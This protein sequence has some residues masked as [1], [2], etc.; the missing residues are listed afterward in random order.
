[1]AINKIRA[2]FDRAGDTEDADADA[3]ADDKKKEKQLVLCGVVGRGAAATTMWYDAGMVMRVLRA[4]GFY[5]PV[6]AEE[7][8]ASTTAAQFTPLPFLLAIIHSSSS[9]D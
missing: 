8:L 6:I 5:H 3:D 7:V 1:M 2:S 4:H 9:I